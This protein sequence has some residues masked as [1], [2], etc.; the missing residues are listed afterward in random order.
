MYILYILY[1]YTSKHVVHDK[2]M[3]F[4]LPITN[5]KTILILNNINITNHFCYE[6]P[7]QKFINIFI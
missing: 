5:N 4:H 2:Y 6:I 3:E 7:Y 1:I